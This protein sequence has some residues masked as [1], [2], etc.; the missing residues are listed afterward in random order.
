MQPTAD[1]GGADA[2]THAAADAATDAAPT[3][4]HDGALL[5]TD[6]EEAPCTL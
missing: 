5:S 2:A 6:D 4:R 1:G 3:R